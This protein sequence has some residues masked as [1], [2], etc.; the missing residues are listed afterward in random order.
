ME[1]GAWWATFHGISKSWTRLSDQTTTRSGLEFP[2]RTGARMETFWKRELVGFPWNEVCIVNRLLSGVMLTGAGSVRLTQIW[3]GSS[4]YMWTIMVLNTSP[5]LLAAFTT[6]SK[7]MSLPE[8]TC[9][10]K[11]GSVAGEGFICLE[12][13]LA[14]EVLKNIVEWIYDFMEATKGFPG[15]SDSK[16]SACNVE[17][18]V[19]SQVR[20]EIWSLEKGM[21]ICSIVLACRIPWI[22]EPGRLQSI[23]SQR[24]RHDWATNTNTKLKALEKKSPT[25]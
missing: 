3:K 8:I 11:V 22:E 13:S 20:K 15:G 2:E 12:R 7:E 1:R 10:S 21:A 4:F 17:T 24:I 25:E 16:E 23:G 5:M 6:R 14:Q 9:Y 19:W 18:G